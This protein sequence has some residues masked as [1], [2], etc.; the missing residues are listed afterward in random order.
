MEQSV[1]EHLADGMQTQV[2]V[3][4][5]PAPV[6]SR[7]PSLLLC[8]VEILSACHPFVT[9]SLSPEWSRFYY[10]VI[11]FIIEKEIVLFLCRC[12]ACRRSKTLKKMQIES[13]LIIRFLQGSDYQ[14]K[15]HNFIETSIDSRD[16]S[17]RNSISRMFRYRLH[18][19]FTS[20]CNANAVYIIICKFIAL[21]VY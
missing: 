14:N 6:Y 12:V 20:I 9:H 11:L 2:R 13:Q 1:F 21:Q 10:N 7:N 18:S 4:S 5:C 8:T 19:I 16:S 17:G 15:S 3:S